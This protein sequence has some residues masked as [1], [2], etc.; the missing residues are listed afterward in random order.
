MVVFNPIDF[1]KEDYA[2]KL[3]FE[4]YCG[5][6]QFSMRPIAKAAIAILLPV[7]FADLSCAQPGDDPHAFLTD[8]KA[9]AISSYDNL[10]KDQL[11]L[12]N[13]V[14]YVKYDLGFSGHP[15][16]LDDYYA[17][18]TIEY[19]DM[20]YHNI[21]LKYDVVEDKVLVEY[22]NQ[23][24]YLR[25][26]ILEYHKVSAFTYEGHQFVKINAGNPVGSL[27]EGF[28]DMLLDGEVSIYASRKKQIDKVVKN[29]KMSIKFVDLDQF[30]V[31][32]ADNTYKVSNK[33]TLLQLFEDHKKELKQY[34]KANRL[35]LKQDF[36]ASL[37]SVTQQYIR[38]KQHHET[39]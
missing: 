37:I 35:D 23:A 17:E 29:G 27:K 24:G 16:F 33:S 9:S 6:V 4:L 13:G 39:L 12:F 15:F 20:V 11:A 34:I 14:E 1:F 22:Y 38:L 31:E 8:A 10:I 36:E 28:Y 2:Y 32:L 21:P 18:G 7:I 5:L 19:D 26:L 3:P 25:G 30:F